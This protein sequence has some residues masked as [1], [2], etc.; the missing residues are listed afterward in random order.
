[1]GSTH[2]AGTAHGE[3][4]RGRCVPHGVAKESLLRGARVWGRKGW[5]S[6]ESDTLTFYLHRKYRADGEVILP[7]LSWIINGANQQR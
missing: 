2:V 4:E 1:M 7:G 6:L 5:G 3:T